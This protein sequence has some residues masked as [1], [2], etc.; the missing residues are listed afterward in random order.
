MNVFMPF[1]P[2]HILL[3]FSLM[4]ENKNEKNL[5]LLGDYDT[6]IFSANLLANLFP[7]V[8]VEIAP[9][10]KIKA[11]NN[12]QDFFIKQKMLRNIKNIIKIQKEINR[13]YYFMECH[14]ATAYALYLIKMQNPNMKSIFVED[15]IGTYV[16]LEHKT[17]NFFEIF[18]DRLIYGAWHKN[19]ILPGT[20]DKESSIAALRPEKLPSIFDIKEKITI[21]SNFF[22]SEELKNRIS[23]YINKQFNNI[24]LIFILDNEDYVASKEYKEIVLNFIEKYGCSKNEIAFKFHPSDKRRLVFYDNMNII[25]SNIPMELVCFLYHDTLENIIGGLSTAMITAYWLLSDVNIKAVF[26]KKYIDVTP[27]AENILEIYNSCGIKMQLI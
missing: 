27:Y 16:T 10:S 14:V 5:I 17:K 11:R 2:Y 18:A 12:V 13:F 25:T 20:L 9:M 21:K 15:G 8:N 23:I 6:T 4:L 22:K 19:I 24:K 3:C 1:T 7:D 26:P